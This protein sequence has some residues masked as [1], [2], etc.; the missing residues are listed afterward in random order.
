MER[1]NAGHGLITMDGGSEADV[2]VSYSA[3]LKADPDLAQS[4][5]AD[6]VAA[7]QTMRLE[8]Q[9]RLLCNVLRPR[10][11]DRE[12]LDE[13]TRVSRILARLLERVGEHLLECDE[14]LGLVGA[15]EQE[16]DL[17]S[18]DPGYGGLAIT[19]RLDS[20]M[21]GNRPHFVEY[22]AES[23]ASI[24]FCD[25]LTEVFTASPAMQAWA[26]RGRLRRFEARRALLDALLWAY[27]TYGGR[28]KPTIG[29]I[30]WE[31]V[32]TQR[33]F[34]LCAE[35]FRDA[36]IDAIIADPR[37]FTY[38][39]GKLFHGDLHVTLIYRRVLLHELLE[40]ASEAQPVLQAYRDGAVCMVNSPRSKLLHKKAVF[41]LLSEGR[42][43]L[44]I[45]AE[46]Q[47]V[48]DSTI[49]WTRPLV[50][51][52]TLY[53]GAWTDLIGLVRDNRS[54]FALKPVDDYGGRG[55]VL[56]W[57][58]PQEA[59]EQSIE[60]ALEKHYIVQERVEVPHGEF[61]IWRDGRL[62]N[63]SMLVDTDPLLFRSELR[64]VLTRISAD[65]LLN[66]S[67]GTGSTTPTFLVTEEE[68]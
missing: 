64:G 68:M 50:D 39:D 23:P 8:I 51:G 47:D 7:H 49:P 58:T 41:A 63:V 4:T 29:V 32:L 59:W 60:G 19:S 28:G 6:L 31:N 16:R 30:D 37:R 54:R 34:E 67:A 57:E 42:L 1:Q 56:G 15:S 52:R 3:A 17:W 22:N 65:P 40:R 48:L 53:D 18:V 5:Y 44:E 61:P 9:G 20:F 14:R 55:V 26:H 12:H 21:M 38:R 25:C 35:Y 33:D 13:L 24:G 46:E 45:T 11:I 66:V 43:E 36:G 27:E 62:E 2:A 10:F